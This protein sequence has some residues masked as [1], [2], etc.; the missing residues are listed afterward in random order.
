MS[1][2]DWAL[3]KGVDL[4]LPAPG[5]DYDKPLKLVSFFAG[6]RGPTVHPRYKAVVRISARA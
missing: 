2:K 1:T 6:M 5:S 4:F 3:F